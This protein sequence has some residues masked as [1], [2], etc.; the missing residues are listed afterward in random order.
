M[1]NTILNRVLKQIAHFKEV[2]NKFYL[3]KKICKT[4]GEHCKIQK[5]RIEEC[6][7]CYNDFNTRSELVTQQE[8]EHKNLY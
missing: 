8:N 4:L 5:I 7:D 3:K 2:K 1:D 6:I